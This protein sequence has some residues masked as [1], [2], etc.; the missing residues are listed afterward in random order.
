MKTFDKHQGLLDEAADLS[1]R[2]CGARPPVDERRYAFKLGIAEI[3]PAMMASDGYIGRRRDGE[4]VIRYSDESPRQRQRFTIAHEIAH[5]LIARYSGEDFATRKNRGE[6]IDTEEEL[7]ANRV[8]AE[9]LMPSPLF[10]A[11]LRQLNSR[12]VNSPWKMIESLRRTFDVAPSAAALRVRELRS[13]IALMF[14]YPVSGPAPRYPFDGSKGM[15][16]ILAEGVEKAAA[17]CRNEFFHGNRMC[18]VPVIGEFGRLDIKCEGLRR[19][20]TTKDGKSNQLWILG[21]A[22]L[23]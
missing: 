6:V 10:L 11:H 15:S 17:R 23:Q 13:V 7:L 14:R 2:L 16:F 12:R 1:V 22:L 21:W 3:S 19:E 9:I 4:F 5:L 8:A 20:L 18:S